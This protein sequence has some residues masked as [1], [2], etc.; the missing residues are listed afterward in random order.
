MPTARY[1][2]MIC[3]DVAGGFSAIAIA[4]EERTVS[5]GSSAGNARLDLREYLRW[6]HKKTSYLKGPDFLEPE[7]RWFSVN[8]RPEYKGNNRL[9]PSETQ[10]EVRVPI[11]VGT[12]ANGQPTADIPL[13]GIQFDY[14]NRTHLPQLVERYVLQKLE[15]LTP[16]ELGAYLPPAEV[17]LTDVVV[18]VPREAADPQSTAPPPPTLARIAEPVGDRAVRKGFARAWGRE[19]E[20]SLL[21]RLLHREKAN[22]LLVGDAGVGKTTLMVDA[23]KEAE[24]LMWAESESTGKKQ[25]RFWLTSAGRLV[26]GMKYLGQWEERVEAAIEELG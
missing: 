18:P 23:V 13:L 9:Y 1:P 8:V 10:V 14:P 6:H 7:L 17:E 26:A 12:R 11:V 19:I 25:R 24:K 21:V 3:R 2:V 5:F 4:T 16:E 22:V 20:L 15:G